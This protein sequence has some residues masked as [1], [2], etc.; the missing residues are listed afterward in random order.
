MFL[1]ISIAYSSRQ[2]SVNDYALLNLFIIY[3][4]SRV[5]HQVEGMSHFFLNFNVTITKN[6]FIDQNECHM[7]GHFFLVCIFCVDLGNRQ[8]GKKT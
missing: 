3:F 8:S 5:D 7:I 1:F 4:S 2:K 6:S